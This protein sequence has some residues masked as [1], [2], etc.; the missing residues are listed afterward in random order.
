MEPMKSPYHARQEAHNAV[1]A[2]GVWRA[3]LPCFIHYIKKA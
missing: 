1:V 3:W 2:R